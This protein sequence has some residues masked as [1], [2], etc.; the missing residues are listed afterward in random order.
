MEKLYIIKIGGNVIDNPAALDA[1][2]KDF[3]NLKGN[4][5]LVH[6]GGKMASA[7]SE[8]MGI[9][10]VMHEGRRITDEATLKVVT[11][12][13]AGWVNK[14]IVAAL[15]AL[16]INAIGLSG[17]DANIIQSEKRPVKNI[18]FG[19]VGDVKKLNDAAIKMLIKNKITPVV[20]AITHDKKGQLLNTNADTIAA[21]LGIAM[22]KLYNVQL[23]YCFEKAGVLKDSNN[24]TSL[25]E[26]IDA[27]LYE[28]LKKD[29]TI[30][31]GMLPK[32]HNCFQ[33]LQKGVEAVAI[34]QSSKLST[35]HAKKLHGTE[36]Y[37]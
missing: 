15:Q 24:E 5:I 1:F 3:S 21:E 19:F 9:K 2:L 13:Y 6:G 28:L 27:K 11:M 30:A 17:A 22:A 16:N 35:L 12:M 25:I 10:P 26:K 31:G 7:L 34:M 8:Q 23:V 20:C 4:K 36:L 29:G 37:L 18:D 33:A 14:N 32:I